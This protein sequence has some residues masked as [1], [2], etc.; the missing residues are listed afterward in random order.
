MPASLYSQC[1]IKTDNY[2][3]V[4][5]DEV[6]YADSISSGTRLYISSRNA[7]VSSPR[8][9]FNLVEGYGQY[10]FKVTNSANSQKIAVGR[11]W[12][13]RI[14][15]TGAGKALIYIRDINV[16]FTTTESYTAVVDSAIACFQRAV[17]SGLATLSDG[18]YG[19]V[20][21]SGGG[22]VLTVDKPDLGLHNLTDGDFS[23]I[24]DSTALSLTNTRQITLQTKNI[25]GW[26]S[27]YL[28]TN[29]SLTLRTNSTGKNSR[30]FVDTTGANFQFVN[31]ANNASLRI[32]DSVA[33]RF[34]TSGSVGQVLTVT[35]IDGDGR[36]VIN[37]KAGGTGTANCE[38]TL[39]KTSHGFR[40]WTPIYWNG[41]TWARPTYDSIIPSYIVVDSTS[42]N[43]FKVANCG[44]YS[45]TL[46]SGL[47]YYKGTSPGYSLTP[48]SIPTPLF[49]VVQSRLI[50]QPLIGFQLAGGSGGGDVTSSVLAD[51]AAAIRAD[52]PS[53][54]TDGDKGDITVSGGTW[55]IDNGVINNAKVASQTLDSTDLKNRSI[56]LLKISQSSAT[57]GQIP[58]WNGSAWVPDTDVTGLGSTYAQYT[59]SSSAPA[60]TNKIWVNTTSSA[61]NVNRI[62]KWELR[63]WKPYAWYDRITKKVRQKL[64]RISCDGQSNSGG[65]NSDASTNTSTDSLIGAWNGSAWVV[66]TLGVSPFRTGTNPGATVYNNIV[67]QVAKLIRVD[68]DAIVRIVLNYQDA[69]SITA[70]VD[71]GRAEWTDYTTKISGSGIDTL[72]YHI[73]IQGEA[74]N[75][76][77]H[78]SYVQKFTT[79]YGDLTALSVW[80]STKMVVCGVKKRGTERLQY[81]ALKYLGSKK[82]NTSVGWGETNG[83]LTASSDAHY[84]NANLLTL[85][86]RVWT[87][88]KLLPYSPTTSNH[89]LEFAKKKYFRDPIW[90][91]IDTLSIATSDVGM[92]YTENGKLILTPTNGNYFFVHDLVGGTVTTDSIYFTT[93]PFFDHSGGV[94][95]ADGNFYTA[96]HYTTNIGKIH[97]EKE[98]I[99]EAISTG[100]L[101]TGT[102][103][104]NNCVARPNGDVL[105][106]PDNN[107]V[108]ILR[109]NV[110]S[111]VVDTLRLDVDFSD[112]PF[113]GGV[114]A[115]NGKIV[116]A[117]GSTSANIMVINTD[118]TITFIAKT[119]TSGTYNGYGQGALGLDGKI[120]FP[121]FSKGGFSPYRIMVFNPS[122][123]SFTETL[124]YSG[125]TA[126]NSIY[127]SIKLA[128]NGKLYAFPNNGERILEIDPVAVTATGV[129]P[130]FGTSQKVAL[131][132]TAA[133]GSIYCLG[134]G[135]VFRFDTPLGTIPIEFLT[136]W[137]INSN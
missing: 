123:N 71:G 33:V 135:G 129:G 100:G 13:T 95:A 49:E 21:V 50:L 136:S 48:T 22:L 125:V 98:F 34:N 117:G 77:T 126:T 19:D 73:W 4:C 35:S 15:S 132:S 115:P 16:T 45:S 124:S 31:G 96:P 39:T 28:Q 74:D 87:E 12:V 32:G 30:I 137:T 1:L 128:P 70:W 11:K 84:Q 57:V 91:D 18:D 62:Y 85:A 75:N 46:S 54:V 133:D 79:L 94:I 114:L 81:T 58:K 121:Q 38:Q 99:Y 7:Y 120:Y 20:V 118:N 59:F 61:M 9:I 10:F 103:L 122:D 64:I 89:A 26:I 5:A 104:Y 8:S 52:F 53:G 14:D 63:E 44:N 106:L 134:A 109:Y 51:T 130:T 80:K 110:F 112:N 17:S 113:W 83:L 43:T 127:R 6:R 27:R 65:L 86:Q 107:A 92:A 76:R 69:T 105:F 3:L 56:T 42:A 72:N 67:F 78:M 29:N 119:L 40:K 25:D 36:L 68:R 131:M 66:A 88:L 60:D 41:S 90:Y 47:Y 2:R 111:G 24:A 102:N 93:G 97:T 116:C 82:F 37:P 23:V 101:I 55:I 108:S